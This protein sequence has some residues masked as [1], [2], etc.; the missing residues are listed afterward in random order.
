[1]KT[2]YVLPVPTAFLATFL[3]TGAAAGAAAETAPPCAADETVEVAAFEELNRDLGEFLRRY[4]EQEAAIGERRR[5]RLE[6][7]RYHLGSED[8]GRR[9]RDDPAAL[10]EATDILRGCVSKLL[11]ERLERV[12]V[13]IAPDRF[14]RLRSSRTGEDADGLRLRISPSVHLG[15]DPSLGA[16]LRLRGAGAFWTRWSLRYR[17]S[18]DEDRRAVILQ[19]ADARHVV[20]LEHVSDDDLGGEQVLVNV[21]WRF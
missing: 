10:E 16:K 19:Y 13:E 21:R 1:M 9:L 15:H 3:A 7:A 2:V 20:R 17:Q 5:L 4:R 8:Y 14:D 18:L 11:R 6:V 12:A